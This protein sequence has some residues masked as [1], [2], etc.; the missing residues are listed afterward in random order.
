MAKTVRIVI[1]RNGVVKAEGMDFAGEGCL[2]AIKRLT[3]GL[4]TVQSEEKKPEFYEAETETSQ[5]HLEQ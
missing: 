3:D 2:E 4:G 1:G 5:D